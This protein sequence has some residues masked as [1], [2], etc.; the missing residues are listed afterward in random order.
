MPGACQS[1][2]CYFS[3]CPLFDYDPGYESDDSGMTRS[4]RPITHGVA[5]EDESLSRSSRRG[6]P[7]TIRRIRFDEA[8]R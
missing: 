6:E 4:D 1:F 2:M 3:L 7:R 8:E 5:W